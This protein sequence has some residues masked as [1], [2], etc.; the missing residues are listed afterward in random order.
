MAEICTA[1]NGSGVDTKVAPL[2]GTE[3][4]PCSECGGNGKVAEV[5]VESK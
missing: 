2:P 3:S 4:T 5:E 1:C